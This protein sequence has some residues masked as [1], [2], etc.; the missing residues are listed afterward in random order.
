MFIG[1]SVGWF[2]SVVCLCGTAVCATC[3]VVL[4]RITPKRC[5]T[6]Q[7]TF[8]FLKSACWLYN[9]SSVLM[10]M[11]MCLWFL[12]SM[13]MQ[14]ARWGMLPGRTGAMEVCDT[15]RLATVRWWW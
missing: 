1:T 7:T 9:S 2:W 14:F 15:A 5:S 4:S 10:M 8:L 6:R 12:P 11:I 13:M 3:T